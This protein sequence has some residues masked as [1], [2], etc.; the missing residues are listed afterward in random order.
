MLG[1]SMVCNKK[2]NYLSP[3]DVRRI[4]D[5]NIIDGDDPTYQHALICPDCWQGIAREDTPRPLTIK[6]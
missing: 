3:A 6:D 4:R 2:C 1:F 5:G